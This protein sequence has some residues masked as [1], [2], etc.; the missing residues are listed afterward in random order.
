MCKIPFKIF[1]IYLGKIIFESCVNFDSL[2]LLLLFILPIY[3]LNK[4]ML[5]YMI[6]FNWIR[7][8]IDSYYDYRSIKK[9]FTYGKILQEMILIKETLLIIT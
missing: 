1:R 7:Y 2:I 8:I 9:K 4:R 3:G 5:N 6:L